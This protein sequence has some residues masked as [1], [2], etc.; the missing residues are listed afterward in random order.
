M[1]VLVCGSRTFTDED[2]VYDLLWG[3]LTSG[4]SDMVIIEGQ[5]PYGGADALAETFAKRYK[6]EHLP[7]VPEFDANGHVLGPKRNKQ[8]LVE[9]KPD[10]VLAFVDKPLETSRGT[11]NMVKQ[12]RNDGVPTYVIQAMQ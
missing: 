1:R 4:H 12:A 6:V 10:L 2:I 9:G 3:M 11:A 7:F 8:M 5:C